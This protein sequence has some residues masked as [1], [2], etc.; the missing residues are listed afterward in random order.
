MI[1]N[2]PSRSGSQFTRDYPLASFRYPTLSQQERGLPVSIVCMG[3]LGLLAS[4]SGA[5][6]LD[7][8]AERNQQGR[9]RSFG[10][11]QGPDRSNS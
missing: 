2:P 4:K 9:R 11:A 10:R 1:Q 3:L 6:R 5:P 8:W 7:R